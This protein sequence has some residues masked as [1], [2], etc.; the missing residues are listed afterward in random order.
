MS[1][2]T[3]AVLTPMLVTAYL[4]FHYPSSWCPPA[5]Q[6][7]AYLG[8][9]TTPNFKA[10]QLDSSLIQHDIF[11]DMRV[12][13]Y[14]STPADHYRMKAG[15]RG[16]YLHWSLPRTYRNAIVASDSA[17][18]GLEAQKQLGGYS[19]APDQRVDSGVP[20]FREV[21]T[22]WLI[23]RQIERAT[24]EQYVMHQKMRILTAAGDEVES[25]PDYP[26]N[27]LFVVESDI[28]RHIDDIDASED[29]EVTASPFIDYSLPLNQQG[30]VFLGRSTKFADWTGDLKGTP[31]NS[32]PL[33]VSR[34]ANPFFADYQP[35]NAGVF[36]FFDDLSVGDGSQIVNA[37]ISY[38]VVGYHTNQATDPLA[39]PDALDQ[40]PIDRLKACL[41]N[42]KDPSSLSQQDQEWLQASTGMKMT[43]I[44]H[45]SIFN[46]LWDQCYTARNRQSFPVINPNANVMSY[47]GDLVQTG[48]WR[49]HP[50]A[51]G[52]NPIDA[53]FGW[54]RAQTLSSGTALS[55]PE[56]ISLIKAQLMKIQTLV[57]DNNDDI[58]SELQAQ[59][60]LATNNFIPSNAGVRWHFKTTG[61]QEEGH[62]LPTDE[63]VDSLRLMN[64]KQSVLNALIRESERLQ[65]ELFSQWW[66]YIC[67][68]DK[69]TAAE[70]G[71]RTTQI[72][73]NVSNL[74]D[75]ISQNG[76]AF[77]GGTL[78]FDLTGEVNA[79]ASTI[80]VLSG[81]EP[82][83]YLQRDPTLFVAGLSSQWPANFNESLPVR[84]DGQNMLGI[85]DAAAK[86]LNTIPFTSPTVTGGDLATVLSA[87]M[88][89]ELINPIRRL[90]YEAQFNQAN[91][92]GGQVPPEYQNDGDRYVGQQGWFPLFI[93]WEIEYYNIAFENWDFG[94]QG[95]EGRVGYS[96]KATVNFEANQPAEPKDD[97]RILTGRCPILPSTSASLEAVLTQVFAKANPNEL[98]SLLPAN[99]RASLLSSVK[100]LDFLSTPMSGLTDQLIT[101]MQGT[102]ISPNSYS[103]GGPNPQILP[104]AQQLAVEIGLASH[105]DLIASGT[106]YTPFASLMSIPAD[107]TRFSPFKPAIHGQFRFTKLNIIDKFG[108]I[109]RGLKPASLVSD[110]I[111]PFECPVAPCLGDSYSLDALANGNANAVLPRPDA[112][113]TFV[114]L[115]PS[116]NQNAR[117]NAEFVTEVSPSGPSTPA[118]WRPMDEW[119]NP[120]QGWIVIN[121]SNFSFQIFSPDGHFIREFGI[122]TNKPIS[123]PFP[124]DDSIASQSS[125]FLKDLMLKFSDPAYLS[126]FFQ[127]ISATVESVQAAPTSYAGS[128]LSVIG[129]PLALVRFGVSLQLADPPLVNQCTV[130]PQAQVSEVSIT[131]YQFKAK[132]GDMDNVFDG[133][134]GYFDLASP[135]SSTEFD[136]T[137]FYSYFSPPKPISQTDPSRLLSSDLTLR[138][139]YPDPHA[140]DY[141]SEINGNLQV[142]AG[143]VDPFTAVHVYTALL[144]IR[145][146]QLPPWTIEQGLSVIS[147]F[148]KFG[149][150]LVPNDVPQFDPTK[151]IAKDYRL[152]DETPM[153]QTGT[154]PIPAIGLTDWGWLQPYWDPVEKAT[155][156]NLLGV[157]A[158]SSI[159]RWDNAPYVATEGFLQMKKPFSPPAPPSPP[160]ASQGPFTAI[161]KS[162]TNDDGIGGY[163]L[164]DATDLAFAFDYDH[165]GKLDHLFLYRPGTGAC[166]IVQNNNGVYSSVYT[167]PFINGKG[168]GEWDLKGRQD[169]AFAFDYYHTGKLDHIFF[170]RPGTGACAIVQNNDGLF[171]CVYFQGDPYGKGIGGY[172]LKGVNDRAFAFDYEHT[173]KLDYIFIYRPGA[174]AC[175]IVKNSSSVFSC[176]YIQGDPGT[177]I[178]GY[179]LSNPIDQVLAFDYEHSGKMDYL[180]LYRPGTGVVWILKNTPGSFSPVYQEGKPDQYNGAGI[181]G[182]DLSDPVDTVIA[183]DFGQCRKLDHLMIYRPGPNRGNCCILGNIN[184]GFPPVY[185][186]GGI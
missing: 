30:Q 137:S 82:A 10:L 24:N 60:L 97:Y 90:I 89:P 176:V 140:M 68:H 120:V 3:R 77:I 94:P 117:V 102:H 9:L 73:Q 133:L 151:I 72:S 156:Y 23:Y 8:A 159:P 48:L 42:V 162:D 135:N 158:V 152:D 184:G 62:S 91:V 96:L 160:P 88:P 171:S 7:P 166:S 49:S 147:T 154:I 17:Q 33:T 106:D 141:M 63:Q 71:K 105:L 41:L 98:E 153:A 109:V 86:D 70:Q 139:F 110:S 53:L 61:L 58:D 52:T 121:Y 129:R 37:K 69:G 76:S 46:V 136:L 78:I 6:D 175:A 146:L 116:I 134:F 127:T 170:Y 169:R 57:L 155:N 111:G 128:M 104:E 22:R 122:A 114:Q 80:P 5:R 115:P 167:Q 50:L 103:G 130:A 28:T 20:N 168:I 164:Q 81:T 112:L 4:N 34:A 38:V 75:R 138:P 165:S 142:F 2:D 145:Q 108:Q 79:L 45:G 180:V 14:P 93:E 55:S 173:G 174:G 83:F 119:E 143:I 107:S 163:N 74:V 126:G 150:I 40:S 51:V 181:G 26:Q 56:D 99:D 118:Q 29:L 124:P 47:P 12:P 183:F 149:P 19:A 172:D 35:Q 27:D 100:S 179:N 87:K 178:G 36:S 101:R 186:A 44:C 132:L 148:F 161:Y 131:D 64:Q 113:C 25:S 144:P 95:P 15:R 21:P 43:N 59:D 39:I 182:W 157:E 31:A 13:P 177:G 67:D 85:N 1:N 92:S 11:E 84:L 185:W 32:V 66:T 54:L 123:R 65:A 18:D 16:I 125:P